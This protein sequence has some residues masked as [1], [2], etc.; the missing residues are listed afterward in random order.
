MAK[1]LIVS[2]INTG[3]GHKSISDAL[4]EQFEK[5]DGLETR[6]VD[7]FT[8]MD[9][10][11]N[12]LL[13]KTYGPIT[14]FSSKLWKTLYS[15][16]EKRPGIAVFVV[17]LACRKGFL[18]LMKEFH[19]DYIL[20]VHSAFCGSLIEIMER[21]GI[22]VPLAVH[23]AD[24]INIPSTWFDKRS[25]VNLA[26]TQEAYDYSI[27]YGMDPSRMKLVG[28]PVRSIFWQR[29]EAVESNG[30]L[31][32]SGAEGSGKFV[33]AAEALLRDT[34]EHVTIV[35]G[36]NEKL[37]IKLEETLAKAYPGRLEVTGF[38]DD[39]PD[40]MRRASFVVL[41]AS[42][43]TLMEAVALNRPIIVIDA[44]PGQEFENPKLAQNH[45]LGIC[46]PD[47][48]KL[49]GVIE[50]LK[51][52]EDG[53]LTN[54]LKSQRDYLDMDAAKKTAEFI[55]SQIKPLDYE[56]NIKGRKR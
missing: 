13:A 14:R 44:L 29:H 42:P 24:I 15:I 40:R 47:V 4:L 25:A 50:R 16:V 48:E 46:E 37:K 36:R 30:V 3:H 56:V 22:N 26:T 10:E 51:N 9:G 28:F 55:Y 17:R 12:S 52:D 2:S 20:S 7:G 33:A 5:I 1:L 43:N 21:N 53:C 45:G 35:F 39:M 41:R 11:V 23:Q 34:E 31:L 19:P 49:S 38:V 32:L 54:M 18:S 27:A 8:L 6:V